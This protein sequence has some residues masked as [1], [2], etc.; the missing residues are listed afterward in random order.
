MAITIE[1]ATKFNGFCF[2]YGIAAKCKKYQSYNGNI[3]VF[4]FKCN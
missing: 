2:K 1:N 4:K 3:S